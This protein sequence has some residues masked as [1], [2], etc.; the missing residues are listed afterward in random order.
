MSPKCFINMQ[1]KTSK[2]G[3]FLGNLW[4]PCWHVVRSKTKKSK[5]AWEMTV[6][7][8]G[9]SWVAWGPGLVPRS[10]FTWSP[11][12]YKCK[13]Q[14]YCE[15]ETSLGYCWGSHSKLGLLGNK[16]VP[17]GKGHFVRNNRNIN[18]SIHGE[19]LAQNLTT[20][21]LQTPKEAHYQSNRRG[22]S[23]QLSWGWDH[24][25]YMEGA[26]RTIERTGQT[27]QWQLQRLEWKRTY[28]IKQCEGVLMNLS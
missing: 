25:N 20:P 7:A 6:R 13:G 15:A 9:C 1:G 23:I 28:Y 5:S 4:A 26:D 11:G 19:F 21:N 17:K 8:Q 3:S 22:V 14:R 27:Q 16:V 24:G 18:V 12:F 10:K 2:R